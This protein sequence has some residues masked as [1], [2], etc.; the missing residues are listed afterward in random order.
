MAILLFMERKKLVVEGAGAVP[1]AAMLEHAKRFEGKKVVLVVSGGNI[2]F[3]LID[4]IIH[5]GL[6][7]SGRIGMF[8]VT[9]DD[10]PGKIH[11][12]TGIIARHR[13]NIHNIVH[14]R[15]SAGLSVGETRVIFTI[16]TRGRDHLKEIMDGM[17]IKGFMVKEIS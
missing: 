16:E 2:D 14:D 7:S 8:E 15:L 3:M 17:R 5:K 6:L 13:G 1:L 9:I 10:I 4:R 12:L 11:I